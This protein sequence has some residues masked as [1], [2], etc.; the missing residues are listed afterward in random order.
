MPAAATGA[1]GRAAPVT[2]MVAVPDV[3]LEGMD[4]SA[5]FSSP[6]RTGKKRTSSVQVWSPATDW[7][8]QPSLTS[9]KSSLSA[10]VKD[11]WPTFSGFWPSLV[12]VTVFGSELSPTVSRPKSRSLQSRSAQMSAGVSTAVPVSGTRTGAE[13]PVQET[14]RAPVF[15]PSGAPGRKE[16]GASQDSPAAS[17]SSRQGLSPEPSVPNG[18]SV[19]KKSCFGALLTLVKVNVCSTTAPDCSP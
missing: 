17:G 5:A 13:R 1:C 11:T 16:M 3:A 12:T 8:E 7:F 18:P 2:G 6:A 4:S 9:S 19:P 10:P 15:G 14:T